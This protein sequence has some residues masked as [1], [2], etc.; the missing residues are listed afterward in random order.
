VDG[1]QVVCEHKLEAPQTRTV[2]AETGVTKQQLERY[3]ELP[4]DAV[5]YVRPAPASLSREIV[6]HPRYLRPRGREHFLWRHL[7]EPLSKGDHELSRWLHDAFGR[8]GFTPPVPH[9][10]ELW[11]DSD[12]VKKNQENFGKLWDSTR[13]D[14][15]ER[16]TVIRNYRH[17]INLYPRAKARCRLVQVGPAGPTSS[18]LRFRATTTPRDLKRV[19]DLLERAAR[20][21]PFAPEIDE[22]ASRY[23]PFIDVKTPLDVVLAGADQAPEQEERLR[24]QVVPLLNALT[25]AG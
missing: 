7:Y 16:W 19:R 11:G 4:V 9:V 10:G 25:P 24:V 1:R 15:E 3:L 13:A 18:L 21:L 8:L 14:A 5:A 6:Q 20:D 23:G 12:E 22:G 2:Q 17:A